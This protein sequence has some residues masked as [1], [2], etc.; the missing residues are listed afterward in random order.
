[1]IFQGL[2]LD[3]WFMTRKYEQNRMTGIIHIEKLIQHQHYF[4]ADATRPR[5]KLNSI[6]GKQLLVI[7]ICRGQNEAKSWFSKRGGC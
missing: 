5:I 7:T 1:M 3:K 4:S 2:L 6:A